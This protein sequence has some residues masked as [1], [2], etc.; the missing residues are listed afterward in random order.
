MLADPKFASTISGSFLVP[1]AVLIA[2]A[3]LTYAVKT[4]HQMQLA[5]SE[6]REV[7]KEVLPN[8]GTSLRD[9]VARIETRVDSVVDEQRAVAR[10]LKKHIR[11]VAESKILESA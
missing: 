6:I 2:F 5:V 11:D 9:A 8:S 4:L 1:L 10:K 3:I 7:K